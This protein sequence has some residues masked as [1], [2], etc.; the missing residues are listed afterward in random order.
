MDLQ[1]PSA[2]VGR[3]RSARTDPTAIR[4]WP[5]VL[6]DELNGRVHVALQSPS[7]VARQGS[8]GDPGRP[9]GMQRGHD[10]ETTGAATLGA[11]GGMRRP[12]CSTG[13]HRP[14]S[15]PNSSN[16]SAYLFPQS[17]WAFA[18]LIR[19]PRAQRA[20]RDT[21]MSCWPTAFHLFEAGRSA[22]NQLRTAQLES[23]N[24]AVKDLN[25][26]FPFVP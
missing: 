11:Q 13:G 12:S 2:T 20:D 23:W 14:G 18:K 26:S 8:A 25:P 15:R 3:S 21:R 4:G 5:S 16:T 10:N 24:V 9:L 1:T 6:R 22:N 17:R 19:S 7:A